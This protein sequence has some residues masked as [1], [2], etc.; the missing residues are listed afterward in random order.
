MIELAP[1]KSIELELVPDPDEP[2][3]MR[4]RGPILIEDREIGKSRILLAMTAVE[5]VPGAEQQK[6]AVA[7]FDVTFHANMSNRFVSA[8]IVFRLISPEGVVF[9][10][11]Q[12]N[13][14]LVAAGEVWVDA[15]GKMAFGTPDVATAE[16]GVGR[17]IHF[18]I[19]HR[20]VKA[21]G[22]ASTWAKWQFVETPRKREGIS[23]AIQLA[24]TLPAEAPIEM[25]LSIVASLAKPGLKELSEAMRRMIFKPRKIPLKI[26][27]PEDASSQSQFCFSSLPK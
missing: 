14:V 24:V 22:A 11:C 5:L 12:P 16:G 10:D 27:F 2:H 9:L 25:E 6:I 1:G 19:E 20:L 23:H 26:T 7:T 3:E 4:G 18:P 13:E 8:E 15:N 21:S 17:K